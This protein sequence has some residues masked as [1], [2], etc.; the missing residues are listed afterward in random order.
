MYDLSSKAK[1]E[2]PSKPSSGL[3]KHVDQRKQAK[4]AFGANVINQKALNIPSKGDV[5]KGLPPRGNANARANGAAKNFSP[6]KDLN[7][8]PSSKGVNGFAKLQ[9][10]V[11]KVKGGPLVVSYEDEAPSK[12]SGNR[13]SASRFEPDLELRGESRYIPA[14]NGDQ[15]DLLLQNSRKGKFS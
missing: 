7:N 5:S 12:P 10:N 8:S 13:G 9:L 2:P 11:N 3:N 14:S 6:N 15:I 1:N 4:V